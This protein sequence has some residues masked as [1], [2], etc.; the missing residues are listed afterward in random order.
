[1]NRRSLYPLLVLA[2]AVVLLL[3]QGPR[4]GDAEE[5]AGGGEQE[6]EASKPEQA[7]AAD[8]DPAGARSFLSPPVEPGEGGRWIE[9]RVTD[10]RDG[11]PLAE[12]E[13][14]LLELGPE[15][16]AAAEAAP[17]GLE[18][19][20]RTLGRARRSGSDG[21]LRVPAPAG[22]TAVLALHSSLAALATFG[23]DSA[24]RVELELRP[25]PTLRVL[26]LE[27]DGSPAPD[28]LVRLRPRDAAVWLQEG[29]TDGEGLATFPH[30][31]LQIGGPGA[32]AELVAA[33]PLLAHAA[34]ES[35]FALDAIPADPVILRLPATGTVEVLVDGVGP[36]PTGRSSVQLRLAQ[37]EAA[38]TPPGALGDSVPATGGRARLPV[39]LG[40]Q[41]QARA[42]IDGADAPF[43]P[44]FAGPVRA[45][46][47]VTIRL[48][49][50]AGVLVLAG[51]LLHPDRRP[52][53][54]RWIDAGL[55]RPSLSGDST[56][57]TRART[58]AE[59]DFLLRWPLEATAP[60]PDR[61]RLELRPPGSDQADAGLELVLPT[62]L[63]AGR[64]ELGER[65]LVELPLLASGRLVDSQGAGIADALLMVE[66]RYEL[67]RPGG[68]QE[69]WQTN[70]EWS[71]T[72]GQDG[73]FVLRG[74]LPEL[75]L[76]LRLRAREFLPLV[77]PFRA[78]DRGLLLQAQRGASLRGSLLL[79]EGVPPSA[80]A[81]LLHRTDAEASPNVAA[82]DREAGFA[83]D[84]L[85]PG[86][87]RV[88]V[89]AGGAAEA[90]AEIDAVLV[91]AG[92]EN[93]DP[94]LQQIDLR[95][96]LRLIRIECV[97]PDGA[98]VGLAVVEEAGGTGEPRH[99]SAP[100]GEAQILSDRWPLDLRVRAAGFRSTTLRGVEQDRRVVLRRGLRVRLELAEPPQLPTGMRLGYTLLPA[101]GED[102][103]SGQRAPLDADGRAELSLDAPGR[104]RVMP[105]LWV[106]TSRSSVQRHSLGDPAAAAV[107]EV[108]ELD[109][110]QRF[111]VGLDAEALRVRLEQLEAG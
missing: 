53:A 102:F 110:L 109:E 87:Y 79:P 14:L 39:G 16:A 37:P 25:S 42:P 5:D 94:R 74:R 103:G 10:A 20:F 13:V 78:G 47:T 96:R 52:V 92:Q 29:R 56:H 2:A 8:R 1:M 17:A 107:I 64:V 99:W 58:N 31:G 50:E 46:Q 55:E 61:L 26:L 73:A 18:A 106:S 60:R 63:S 4:E 100:H 104:Y 22:E 82:T 89:R 54:E 97:D 105:A 62:P 77:Q 40:L 69:M 36:P 81:V 59:G 70:F 88:E 84:R 67:N 48:D 83:W 57:W 101:D 44:P 93:R 38:A 27:A 75:P 86:L 90:L 23:P 32:A 98:A 7:P 12:A 111:P 76:R 30:L 80:L 43:G 65:V 3:L 35:V 51:R 41:L 9:L 72:T 71:A 28:R 19:R 45:G 24:E 33:S 49:P 11:S 15:H 95:Q 91:E 68:A 34:V 85:A 21:S 66:E 108:L 6:I